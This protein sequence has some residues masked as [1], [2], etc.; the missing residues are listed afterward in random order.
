MGKRIIFSILIFLLIISII[1]PVFAVTIS[2]LAAGKT[3]DVVQ[4]GEEM[5]QNNGEIGKVLGNVVDNYGTINEIAWYFDMDSLTSYDGSVKN[6]YG[7]IIKNNSRLIYVRE[8]GLVKENSGTITIVYNNAVVEHNSGDIGGA[9]EVGGKVI[10]NTGSINCNV[11]I[12][13]ENSGTV[14]TNGGVLSPDALVNNTDT[15]IVENNYGIVNG[16]TVIN[17]YGTV[18]NGKVTN[19]YADGTVI[20]GSVENNEGNASNSNVTNNKG[21]V[22]SGNVENNYSE[23]ITNSTITNNYSDNVGNDNIIKNNFVK[24]INN[25]TIENQ[26]YKL[27]LTGN[28]ELT[29]QMDFDG[30]TS[31]NIYADIQGQTWI[32]EEDSLYLIN[33]EEGYK[34]ITEPIVN[35]SGNTKYTLEGPRMFSLENV[36]GEVSINAVTVKMHKLVFDANGGIF[37]NGTSV[38][39]YK[40]AAECDFTNVE[41]PKREGYA[42]VGYYT[43]E[44]KS[45]EEI[46]GNV[47]AGIEED[48]FFKARWEETTTSN[49]PTQEPEQSNET[50]NQAGQ[51]S[52]TNV[53]NTLNNPQTGDDIILFVIIFTISAVGIFIIKKMKKTI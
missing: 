13:E 39:E 36:D 41:E 17:N 38:I 32:R 26:Y 29:V 48:T 11:G 20:G 8:N 53:Q 45:F 30:D 19:N 16:G 40:D 22:S 50:P 43:D 2:D 34:F 23:Q 18:N 4:P 14:T 5:N 24:R 37:V 1:I 35:V 21:I 47:E 9:I 15:G 51:Q 44:G 3:L 52:N 28:I 6:N 46:C 27:N 33:A 25:A 49:S 7:T 12:V 42:F 10:K 31:N